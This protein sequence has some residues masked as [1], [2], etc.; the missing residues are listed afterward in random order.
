MSRRLTFS[1]LAFR[2]QPLFYLLVALI[3][4]MSVGSI[5]FAPNRLIIPLAGGIWA[6]AFWLLI[7]RSRLQPFLLCGGLFIL[8]I[9]LWGLDRDRI[10]PDRLKA[11]IDSE[12][13]PTDAPVEIWG[14]LS[15][16]PELAPDRI[17]LRLDVALEM[18]TTG[19]G[20][21]SIGR[22][23]KRPTRTARL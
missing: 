15:E 12:S 19:C 11:L 5:I 13:I 2:E 21:N 4:G 23:T 17:Y 7:C 9:A 3:C 8:G 16:L 22:P 20:H 10:G 18:R 14:T 1:Q 6:G